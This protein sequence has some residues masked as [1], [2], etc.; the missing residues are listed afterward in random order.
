MNSIFLKGATRKKI[1]L[2][3]ASSKGHFDIQMV[4]GL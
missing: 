2:K 3:G 4:H 1:F